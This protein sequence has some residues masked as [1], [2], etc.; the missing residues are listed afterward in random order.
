MPTDE[1]CER[2]CHGECFMDCDEMRAPPAT[3]PAGREIFRLQAQVNELLTLLDACYEVVEL[4]K[5]VSAAQETWKQQWLTA[6]NKQIK[7]AQS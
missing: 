2:E 6:A 7:G 4:F 5:P 3:G 1:Q